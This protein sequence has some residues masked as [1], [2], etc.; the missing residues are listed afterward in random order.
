MDERTF[1]RRFEGRV[2][3]V[4]GAST[5]PGIGTASARRLALEGAS[6]VINARTE[7]RLRTTERA[8]RDEGLAVA[9]VPGSAEDPAVPARLVDAALERFGRIDLLVNA[10]GGAN[11]I[12]SA[13]TMDRAALIDTLAVNTWP[14]L[15]LIQEAMARG[16]ADGGGS[17]VNISSGSP[18]KTTPSMAAYAAAKSAL[19]ALTRTLANDLG[20]RGVRVNA[21]SPGLTQTEATRAM[22]EGD[23]GQAAGDNLLLG[24]M[25]EPDDIAA[26]VAF[27]LSDEAGS[28]TGVLLDVDAGNH[29]STGSWSPFSP[30][31]IG[32]PGGA[33]SAGP[34]TAD[35]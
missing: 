13:L 6:V 15:A 16:L 20:S 27:L 5:D 23:G 3:I 21:V 24:R 34:P 26:A 31:A 35:R 1:G 7:D 4:T 30:S 9:A 19:N 17:V 10:V 28:I 32:R 8:L 25:T 12:G 2:A 22:W 14:A 11:H 29:V 33:P 18:K